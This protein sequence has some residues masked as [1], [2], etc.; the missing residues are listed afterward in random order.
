MNRL[1]RNIKRRI[2]LLFGSTYFTL[3]EKI[4]I[5][6]GLKIDN[7]ARNILMRKIVGD[8]PGERYF[9]LRDTKIYFDVD[10]PIN[11]F[12]YFMKGITQVI[13]EAFAGPCLSSHNTKPSVGDVVLDLGACIGTTSLLFQSLVGESGKV[14]AFEPVTYE[15]LKKN[16]RE[17]GLDDVEVISKGVSDRAGKAQIEISDFCLDSSITQRDYTQGYYPTRREIELTT[18]DE[19]AEEFSL[20]RV[21]FIKMDIEGAEQLAIRG[22]DKLIRRHMPKWSISSYHV[23]F[24]NEP[25]HPKLVACLQEYGYRIE[26]VGNFHIYAWK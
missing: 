4:A 20:E 9:Q 6:S 5:V 15:L 13:T 8:R 18:L 22:A 12:T 10:Y 11:D 25:Q 21:D 26:E 3:S 17:N 23:D 2:D 16:L 24:D 7:R 1:I 14:Y 19:M